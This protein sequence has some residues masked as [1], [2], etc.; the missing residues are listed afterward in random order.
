MKEMKINLSHI[1]VGGGLGI[2]YK[3]EKSIKRE[4]F[5]DKLVE[6]ISPTGLKLIVEPGRSIV[7]DAGLLVTKILNIKN[8]GDKNFAI[9]DAAMNDL[10]RPPL[11]NA[12]HRIKNI[13]KPSNSEEAIYDVVGPVCETTDYLG[14][15]RKLSI[16]KGDYLVVEDVGAYGFSLSS[17]YNSRPRIAEYILLED[18]IKLIRSRED[19]SNLI[20]DE[21]DLM[22]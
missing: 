9:V 2:T 20:L 15:D 22:I 16:E 8:S 7:G 19:F 14:K 13:S 5:L 10:L 4:S 11:Y 3:D 12:H 18:E 6:I 17:N 1:D 21:S